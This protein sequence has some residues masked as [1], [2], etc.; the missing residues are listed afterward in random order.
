MT[1]NLDKGRTVVTVASLHGRNSQNWDPASLAADGQEP[2][3][4]PVAQTNVF[5]PVPELLPLALVREK[6]PVIVL[7]KQV[8]CPCLGR[9]GASR[10]RLTV[11]GRRTPQ[12]R[13]NQDRDSSHVCA[14]CYLCAVEWTSAMY[15]P[16]N[17]TTTASRSS[18]L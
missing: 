3:V 2:I 8:I 7:A 12:T 17:C 6:P 10:D 1:P 18:V 16:G 15:P 5:D 9:V 14:W 4:P 13:D 11:H